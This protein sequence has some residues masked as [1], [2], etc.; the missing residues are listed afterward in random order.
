MP[1]GTGPGDAGRNRRHGGVVIVANP[2]GNEK[3]RSVANG[4][5]VAEVIGGAGFDG[6]LVRG[7]IENRV[8]TK[9]RSTGVVVC[10]NAVDEKRYGGG[11]NLFGRGRGT[12]DF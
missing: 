5:V 4:P 3:V 12:F 11:K 1:D 6:D 9:S 8:E 7:K 10:E 2:S